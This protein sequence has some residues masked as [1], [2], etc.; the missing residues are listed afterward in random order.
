M[1]ENIVET[2]IFVRI[3]IF[4]FVSVLSLNLVLALVNLGLSTYIRVKGLK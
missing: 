1:F 4:A 3:L 2:S